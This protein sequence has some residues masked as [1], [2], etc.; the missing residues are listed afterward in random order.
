MKDQTFFQGVFSGPYFPVFRLNAEIYYVDLCI[1]SEF[2]K[3]RIRK[4]S[5][6]GYYSRSACVP[7]S[8]TLSRS[9]INWSTE[10]QA[11]FILIPVIKILN[12]L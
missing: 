3:I 5:V 1:Q 6:F 10:S 12:Y 7:Q 8:Y 11:S 2:G 9:S 4:N